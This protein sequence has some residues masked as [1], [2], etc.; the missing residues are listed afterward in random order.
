MTEIAVKISGLSKNYKTGFF[1]S[2]EVCALDDLNLD[3]T[4]GQI[5]GFLGGNGAGKTTTIKLLM[6]LLF[7]TSG[8][9]EIFGQ[10][11][12]DTD[13][14]S[15]VGY[16]PEN[17][18]FYDYLTPLELMDYFAAIFG[19][20]PNLRKARTEELLAAV[21][22]RE[23]DWKKQLR[24]FSKG[25]LQRVGLAQSLINDPKI[26]ILDEPMSG[27]DPIG[28]REI[29]EL[30]AGLRTQGKTVFMSTHILSDIEA[31][32][33]EV[34]ILKRG[35]LAATGNLQ[36]LLAREEASHNFEIVVTN[37][38]SGSLQNALVNIDGLQFDQRPSGSMIR[39]Q[40]ESDIDAVLSAVRSRSGNLISIQQVRQ[41]LEDLFTRDR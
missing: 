25:M 37:V 40:K 30:I 13:V 6:G 18:Y 27:L 12:N 32:C 33:D 1:K 7:P 21:G 10:S 2:K 19:L 14:H 9:A 17:P 26:V 11:I 39:C 38:D 22:L 5:F 31:L 4:A 35:K 36:D 28:R 20:S 34:A 15:V 8:T 41:S 29:R 24:K 23:S 16:C 3:V